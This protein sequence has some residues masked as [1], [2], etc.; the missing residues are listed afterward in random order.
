MLDNIDLYSDAF[1]LMAC[2]TAAL[3]CL[4]LQ[5]KLKALQRSEKGLA[6][7]LKALADATDTSRQASAEIK[8]QIAEGLSQLDERAGRVHARRQEIEDLLDSMEGQ[9]ALQV[10]RC[11]DARQLTEK[12]LTPLVHKAEVE[13]HALTKALE[14]SSQMAGLQ[15]ATDPLRHDPAARAERSNPD[16]GHPPPTGQSNNPFLRAVGE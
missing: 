4:K 9:M 7:A 1:L 12:A 16:I 5:T 13:I 10:R 2:L 6:Q 15:M 8:H 11:H 3:F 14:L